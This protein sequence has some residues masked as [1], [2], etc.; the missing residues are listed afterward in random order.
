MRNGAE[1]ARYPVDSVIEAVSSPIWVGP[2]SGWTLAAS[3]ARRRSLP[4][5]PAAVLRQAAA[6]GFLCSLA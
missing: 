6:G 5:V 4:A 2:R 3:A 1:T